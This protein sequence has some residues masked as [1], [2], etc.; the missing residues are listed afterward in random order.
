MAYGEGLAKLSPCS[1]ELICSLAGKYN[2]GGG[3]VLDLGCGRGERLWELMRCYSNWRFAGVDIDPDM[4]NMAKSALPEADIRCC[5]AELLPFEDGKFSLVICE[6]S[7][8]LFDRPEKC[9]AEAYRVLAEGG[10]LILGDIIGRSLGDACTESCGGD[11]LG[12]IRSKGGI[13]RMAAGAG[14]KTVSYDDRSADLTAMAAQMIF[15]GSICDC[16]GSGGAAM[17]RRV[18]AGYGLWIFGK[19]EFCHV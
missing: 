4:A 12:R 10:A 5:D 8:S 7:L 19:E 1:P 6:C 11:I 14:F 2:C 16:L 17:L 9:L 3:E 18:K 15:D 13:E